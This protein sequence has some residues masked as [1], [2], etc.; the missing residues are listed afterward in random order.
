MFATAGL[1]N[2]IPC[3]YLPHCPR[4]AFCIYSHTHSAVGESPPPSNATALVSKTAKRKLDESL[5]SRHASQDTQ[6]STRPAEEPSAVVQRQTPIAAMETAK[7]R[8]QQQDS[9]GLVSR[10]VSASSTRS[11]PAVLLAR[12]Q[13]NAKAHTT[14]AAVKVKQRGCLCMRRVHCRQELHC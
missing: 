5:P 13:A 14:L 11:Q 7:R 9:I 6:Q 4:H 10:S 12:P 8:K 2:A 3:P 1:F